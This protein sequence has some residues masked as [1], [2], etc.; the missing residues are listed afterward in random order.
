ML[1]LA[2][3]LLNDQHIF[4]CDFLVFVAATVT[5]TVDFCFQCSVRLLNLHYALEV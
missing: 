1:F 5:F 2:L 3:L 4:V